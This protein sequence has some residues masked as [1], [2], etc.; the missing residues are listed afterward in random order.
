MLM[1][2]M[3]LEISIWHALEG[4]MSGGEAAQNSEHVKFFLWAMLMMG[5]DLEINIWHALK[6]FIFSSK[7]PKN[8]ECVISEHF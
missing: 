6:G 8:N 5:M 4:F 3:D 1:M 7:A 2:G